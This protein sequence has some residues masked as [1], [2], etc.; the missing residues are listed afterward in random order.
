MTVIHRRPLLQ[1][2]R[3]ALLLVH[4]HHPKVFHMNR[5]L[6]SACILVLLLTAASCADRIVVGS[7]PA[8]T[9]Q[10]PVAGTFDKIDISAPVDAEIQVSTGAVPSVQLNGY[11]NLLRYVK[12]KVE[13]GTLHIYVDDI[14]ELHTE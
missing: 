12:T 9:E 8:R 3:D 2:L 5:L 14:V 10:R 6:L 1:A 4:L 7:G 11:S 13:N